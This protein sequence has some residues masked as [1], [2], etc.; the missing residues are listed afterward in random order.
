MA[1]VTVKA[2][3]RFEEDSLAL[4]RLLGVLL[5]VA[6]SWDEPPDVLVV[7]AGSDGQHM[8]GSRHYTGEAIDVRSH[9]FP[10]LEAKERF[11][12]AYQMALGPRFRVL[13]ESVGTN[14]EHFHAQVMR[15]GTYP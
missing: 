10:T 4:G 8:K 2:T 5:Q 6:A 13:F 12:E 14:N 15:G 7:T 9:N 3:V 11:R 1:T